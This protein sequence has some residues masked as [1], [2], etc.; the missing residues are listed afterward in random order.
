[1][2]TTRRRRRRQRRRMRRR[3]RRR[4]GM[5][6]GMMGGGEPSLGLSGLF[7]VGKATIDIGEIVTKKAVEQRNKNTFASRAYGQAKRQA[8]DAGLSKAQITQAGK[9]GFKIASLLCDSYF[10]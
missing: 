2:T 10:Q 6:K 3:R 7:K 4:T 8:S 1:M 9:D 5:M